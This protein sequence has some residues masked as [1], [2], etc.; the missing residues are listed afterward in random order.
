MVSQEGE[1]REAMESKVEKNMV[2]ERL[3]IGVLG[4]LHSYEEGSDRQSLL[5][6]DEAI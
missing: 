5:V 4:N 3:E 1:S 2:S 6:K